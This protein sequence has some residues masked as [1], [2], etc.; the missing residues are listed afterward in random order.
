M[1]NR[2]FT[3]RLLC[4]F[5]LVIILNPLAAQD[6]ASMAGSQKNNKGKLFSDYHKTVVTH[7]EKSALA[8]FVIKGT[9]R[10]QNGVVSGV[11]VTEKGTTNATTTDANGRFSLHVSSSNSVVIFTSISY[12]TLEIAVSGRSNIEITLENTA[13]ELSA[14][15]VTALGI[16]RAKKSLGYSVEEVAGKEMN[17]V[18][19]E[20]VLN[21][22]SGKV[23]G[24]TIN[25]TSGSGSS[26]SMIIRGATSLSS[27]N[28]PLFVIDGVPIANTLNNVSQVGNDNRVD[29]GNA[30]GGVNPD[31]IEN[32]SILKGPSAAALYGSRA[33]NGVVLITTKSGKGVRKLTVSLT[34]NTVFE[35]PYKF[36]NWQS[37][38]ASG[39]FPATPVSISGNILTDPLGASDP[40]FN[41]DYVIIDESTSGGGGPELDKGYLGLQWN[42]PLDENGNQIATPLISHPDNVKNFVQTGITTTNGVS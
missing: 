18:A 35:K 8:D 33:G 5:S 13:Q 20:N 41:P 23:A 7:T 21:A 29:Y 42:S 12:K 17:R 27:D 30:M 38:F 24:V 15:V 16:T 19:Q 2:C 1:R 22:M 39:V 11:T 3:A 6:I 40:R 25:Q 10:D 34:S 36:L 31:D 26:V 4:I 9:V 14:V 28:Q 37:Q 32:V